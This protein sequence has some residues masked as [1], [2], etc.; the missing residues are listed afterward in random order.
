[1]PHPVEDYLN[2]LRDVRMTGASTGETSYYEPLHGLLSAI[3]EE[4][5]PQ[6]HCVMQPADAGAGLPD[7]GLFTREQVQSVGATE[8]MRGGTPA[9]GVIEVK[10]TG[11][12]IGPVVDGEQVARYF[13]RYRQVLVTNYRD[14]VFIGQDVDGRRT[15]FGRFSFADSEAD[16]WALAQSPRRA[17]TEQGQRFVDFIQRFMTHAAPLCDPADVAWLLASYA[18]EAMARVDE[19]DIPALATLRG[20]LE[21]ALGL[22]FEGEEGEHF[23]RSTLVQTLFYGIFSAWVIWSRERPPQSEDRFNWHEA[24]WSLHVPM[25]AALYRQIAS[26]GQLRALGV[27]EVLEWAAD[28]LNRIDRASFF[29]RF[30]EGQAVQYFY[31]P[32][33]QAFDPELRRQLG[34]WYTPTEIVRYMVERVDRVLREELEIAD[35]LADPN[36]YVLDPCCGTGAY[37]VEVLR[38]IER[39]LREKQDNGLLAHEIKQAAKERVFGFEILPAP[40]V[41]AHLQ[42]GLTLRNL[43]A[44]LS[45]ETEERAGIYLTNALTGW[46]PPDETKPRL[47]YEEF[48]EEMEAADSVKRS[49]P[50]LVVLGN[51]PYNGFAG[52]A[53]GEERNL[54][55]AYRETKDA[56]RPEGQGLNDLYVRFFRIA[57]RQIVESMGR[58]VVCFIS[59]YSWLDSLSCTG[60]RERYLEAFDHIWIDNLN[61][62]KYRTGKTTPEGNPDPSVFSTQSN[63][64][65]IQVGTAIAG[66]VRLSEHGS[67]AQL[68]YR[69]FWGTQKREDLEASLDSGNPDYEVLG[70]HVELGYPFMPRETARGYFDW[71]LLPD[72]FPVF[73][74]GVQT[75][76]D[77][78]LVDVDREVLIERLNDYF[79]VSMTDA[80]VTARHPH[81]MRSHARFDAVE[82]RA[83]LVRRGFL[84]GNVRRFAYRPMDV[85]WL[86]W[87][88]DTKFID[89]K[90]AEYARHLT[91]GNPW[92]TAEE[93]NRRAFFYASQVTEV[94]AARHLTES[95]PGFFPLKVNARSDADLFNGEENGF[96]FNLS[97]H[98]QEYLDLIDRD[99]CDLFYHAL[100]IQHAESYADENAGALRQD[101]PRVPLPDRRELLEASAQLGREVAALLDTE[102]GV[103]AVTE[104]H[105]RP[106]LRAMALPTTVDG[107]Q[108]RPEE[109]DLAVTAGWGYLGAR[110]ATMPG[111]GRRVERDYTHEE[112]AALE[113]GAEAL[114]M[115]LDE[116]L[117]QLGRA[118]CDVYLNDRAYWRNVPEGVWNYYIGGY[119]VIKKWL[120]YRERG[121][122]ERPVLGRDLRPD[123]ARYVTEMVRRIG[124][125]L[126]LQPRLDESYQ[127]VKQSV[128]DWGG[129]GA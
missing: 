18:R 34:V 122:E 35:G 45:H 110:D 115:T 32:F 106:E 80:E 13:E 109:G 123:E 77:R 73:F 64:V 116:A 72:L 85:R 75:G 78:F 94:M 68:D 92:M 66:L 41:V 108:L 56:P 58:G 114:G 88:P 39:T 124:A 1:M 70:P 36:V 84:P 76:R 15:E 93:R 7:A 6:V 61:G 22:T 127:A 23:F 113:Q 59:N 125:I 31:E 104:G 12:P 95:G 91:D 10:G 49:K 19:A 101:W 79:D 87:E 97:G 99:W 43:G 16:F 71:P 5:D 112:L 24:E 40:F 14:F 11:E 63:R 100:C 89:E 74:P 129:T 33:L 50:V 46:E 8:I 28:A 121:T 30:D 69:E 102:S 17:A 51:P 52:T 86:Y 27:V 65:G 21:D 81:S 25:I 3:G 111:Q 26:P 118:T 96:V 67:R 103:P 120:S 37:L 119:Q 128:Y 53:I 107:S 83:H 60:M 62:D 47:P 82:A 2:D 9:R 44:P 42:I 48:Q 29:D 105:V 57:E 126:L 90:R 54:V 4:L 20:A 38:R 117:A 98:A 55:E